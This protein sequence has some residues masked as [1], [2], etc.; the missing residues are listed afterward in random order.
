MIDTIKKAILAGVGAAAIT[1]DKA[2][3]ALNELVEKG[4]LSASDAKDAAN[5][6]AEEGKQEFESASAKLQAKIDEL[7]AKAGKG[8]KERIDA[9]EARIA[10]LEKE[11]KS[12]SE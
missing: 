8:Q 5:K 4:K 11:L 2:E 7:L 10:A 9:L 3:A 1:R 6:I 12:E